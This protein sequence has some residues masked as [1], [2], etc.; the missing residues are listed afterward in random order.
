MSI[1][2]KHSVE[3]EEKEINSLDNLKNLLIEKNPDD[4]TS[5]FLTD[6]KNAYLKTISEDQIIPKMSK[7]TSTTELTN[8]EFHR[9]ITHVEKM[10]E[11]IIRDNKKRKEL[12]LI[13]NVYVCGKIYMIKNPTKSPKEVIKIAKD[14]YNKKRKRI[15]ED[16]NERRKILFKKENLNYF[17]SMFYPNSEC[18]KY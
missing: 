5:I 10:L 4:E 14:Y 1:I 16:T 17:G 18:F 12:K 8:E 11:Q 6:G 7:T 2:A 9:K 3:E 13:Y 15:E